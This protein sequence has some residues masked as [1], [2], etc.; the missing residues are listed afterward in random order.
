MSAMWQMVTSIVLSCADHVAGGCGGGRCPGAGIGTRGG[1]AS[2]QESGTELREYS[3]L[4]VVGAHGDGLYHALHIWPLLC[5]PSCIRPAL[6]GALDVL[7]LGP[8]VAVHSAH[9][10]T[11]LLSYTM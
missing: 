8:E 5:P 4:C 3:C 11:R 2:T 6:S 7:T 10:C 9:T 1:A